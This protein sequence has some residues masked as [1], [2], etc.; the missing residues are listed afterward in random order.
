[1]KIWIVVNIQNPETY[2]YRFHVTDPEVDTDLY[3]EGIEAHSRLLRSIHTAEIGP[4]RYDLFEFSPASNDNEH[5]FDEEPT[6][7]ECLINNHDD[8]YTDSKGEPQKSPFLKLYSKDGDMWILTWYKEKQDSAVYYLQNVFLNDLSKW[9]R[10]NHL[11]VEVRIPSVSNGDTN[12]S[13]TA[14][15]TSAGMNTMESDD[16]DADEFGRMKRTPKVNAGT[17]VEMPQFAPPNQN[18]SSGEPTSRASSSLTNNTTTNTTNAAWG[19]S[20]YGAYGGYG[21]YYNPAMS[22]QYPL[23]HPYPQNLQGQSSSKP[24]NFQLQDN[25]ERL[26]ID[27][28]NHILRGVEIQPIELCRI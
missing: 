19:Y 6:I 2:Y 18:R 10:Q 20:A 1:M 4:I 24:Y 9:T 3:H 11:N 15:N 23:S 17:Q 7:S 22:N 27:N 8:L 13:S 16:P 5:S 28:L 25:G 21:S 14:P 26:S 12:A